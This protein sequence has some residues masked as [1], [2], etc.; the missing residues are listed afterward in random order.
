MV[1]KKVKKAAK[2]VK[3]KPKARKAKKVSRKARVQRIKI[4]RAP[5]AL[6]MKVIKDA[7][8]CPSCKGAITLPYEVEDGEII[9]CPDCEAELQV[10][11]VGKNVSLRKLV[12]DYAEEEQQFDMEDVDEGDYEG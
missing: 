6:R 1:K 9:N 12:S 7:M 5:K 10:L 8:I 11:K 3:S 2:G 4:P